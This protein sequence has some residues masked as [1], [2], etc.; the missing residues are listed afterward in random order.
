A[1]LR[2][3]S[4][5]DFE[6]EVLPIL[7][8]NCLACHNQTKAKADLILETPQT[9]LKGGESGPAV[10]PGNGSDSLLLKLAAHSDKPVMP[11][12]ENK[13][14]ARD[15]APEQLALVKLW[16]DQGAKGEIHGQ[17]PVVWQALPPNVKS[18]F[19]VAVTSDGQFAA[20]GRGNQLYLYHIPTR[21]LATRLVD[22]EL[23]RTGLYTNC[24]VAHLDLV[25]ALAFNPAGDLLAS[26]GYREIKLWRRTPSQPRLTIG[27]THSNAVK[28]L[29]ATLDGKWFATGSDD[30]MVKV[31]H[32]ASGDCAKVLTGHE[33]AITTL[34]FSP[35]GT[36]LIAGSTDQ[37]ICIWDLLSGNLFAQARAKE[38]VIA[39]AWLNQRQQIASG[40]P[41]GVIQ[42]WQLPETNGTLTA[43]HQLKGHEGA[44]TSLDLFPGAVEQLVSGS[45][46]GS[47]RVWSLEKNE[48]VLKMDHGGPVASVAVRPDG[49]RAASA[50]EDHVAKLWNLDDGKLV[51]EF[52][53]DGETQQRALAAEKALT[54][55]TSQ[56]NFR[57]NAIDTADKARKA[58]VERV[59]KAT[60]ASITAEKALGE[61]QKG[62]AEAKSAQTAAEKTVA[63]V[64]AELKKAKDEFEAAEAASGKARSEA[65]L[66]INR[67]L[68]TQLTAQA[69]QITTELERITNEML[70][71]AWS[72]T[73]SLADATNALAQV[74]PKNEAEA[75]TA[76][77]S[78][79]SSAT[80]KD[81]AVPEAQSLLAK[82]IEEVAAKAHAAGLAKAAFDRFKPESEKKQKEADEKLKAAQKAVTDAESALKKAELAKSTSENELHLSINAAQR[83]ADG[84]TEAQNS[85]QLAEVEHKQAETSVAISRKAVDEAQRP[86]RVVAF[87]GDNLLIATAGD[88]QKIHT[89][90]AHDGRAFGALS[91]HQAA[92]KVLAFAGEH[93]LVSGGDD[94]SAYI[95][96]ADAEW[97]L[98]RAIGTG[99][100]RSAIVDR[101]NAL[102]FTPDGKYLISGGGEPSRSGELKIWRVSD[103]QLVQEFKNVHSDVVFGIDLTADGKY[104]AS[105][106]ADK[107]IRVLELAT[108]KI[109]RSL[110]GHTHHVLSV[111]WKR[112][113]R[114]LVSG[115]A[116]NI[117]K[118]WD[119]FAGERKKN[120]E[121]FNKEITS[122]Y[123]VGDTDQALA[124][125]GDTSVRLVKENGDK[126]RSFEGGT[127]FLEAAAVT[128]DG[129]LVVA[130]GQDGVLRAWDGTN[131]EL[132]LTL[133]HTPTQ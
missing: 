71:I 76:K 5:V 52:K 113:G 104:L 81:S 67:T 83:A 1:D 13:V 60:E 33:K 98:D 101:V 31:W 86:I 7:K 85:L 21:R 11:P 122:I 91:G 132:L 62:L 133:G 68:Q 2:R 46:D 55:A 28:A 65:N 70:R 125:S 32:A 96:D 22:R 119:A 117:V 102:R 78:A 29:A 51:A 25:Q 118:V 99:D 50:G 82:S 80:S 58:Q 120:I 72:K 87:S 16:I 64:T 53:G 8:N 79:A 108:G 24:A 35:D 44:V 12:K 34:R 89:W 84:L 95:W 18:I 15:L 123:F 38:D 100:E 109:L 97:R 124:C 30:G 116:D 6:Q 121:G 37:R 9:I 14:N 56:V 4:P 10:L 20:C 127:D 107:F 49:K 73:N 43:I 103:G 128:F 57:K 106:A 94:R 40:G 114:T 27:N 88:D 3:N 92:V 90:S 129:S 41:T 23:E 75:N 112:D 131:G 74:G 36:K 39:V 17:A 105:S 93:R 66:A 48:T 69:T 54:Y 42:L 26:G 63:D 47:L 126:V 111:S 61:K 59:K 130:G 45:R 110:E 19:A 77:D 115:G